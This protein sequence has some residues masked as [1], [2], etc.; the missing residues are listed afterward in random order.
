LLILVDDLDLGSKHDGISVRNGYGSL[1]V[2]ELF[3]SDSF[4]TYLFGTTIT[5]SSFSSDL[6]RWKV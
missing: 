3:T 6:S 2:F 1:F 4:V 5:R